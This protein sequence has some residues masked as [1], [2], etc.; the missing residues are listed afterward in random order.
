M[1]ATRRAPGRPAGRPVVARRKGRAHESPARPDERYGPRRLR[2]LYEISKVLSHFAETPEATVP[3]LLPILTRE[4]P[5]RSAILIEKTKDRPTAIVWRAPDV[6][7][8]ELK[9][10]AAR[11]SKSFAFLTRSP[12]PAVKVVEVKA[13]PPALP[14][15]R[16]APDP[17]LHGRYITC[18][19]A[20]QGRPIFGSLHL[21]G[22]EPFDEED[23]EFVN[24]ATGQLAVALE[25]NEVRL[26]EV[27]LRKQAESSQREAQREMDGRRRAEKEV[28]ELNADLERRVAERTAQFQDTI[29][30]L[31][32]FTYSIAHDLRAPL[33]HIHG[34]TQLLAGAAA[35]D[36]SREHAR[37]IMA[38]TEGMDVLIK[39]LLAYSRLTL[40]EI[41]IEPVSLA[42]VLAR[43]EARMDKELKQRKARLEIVGHLP[44]VMGHEA[45]LIQAVSNLLSNSL[46]FTA[47]G[48]A[49]RI[50]VT[51][52]ARGTH[53]RLW[54]E[55]N[56]IGIAPE[57]LERIFGVFQRLH[58]VE[59]YPGTGIGLA[60]VRRALERMKGRTGAESEPGQGSRF[61]LELE[62]A[63]S[64]A[65]GA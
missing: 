8:A 26:H 32:A 9:G 16:P 45:S 6:T 57:H 33:R 19:L 56:G 50:R 2:A 35:D 17:A 1:A 43:A 48:V 23:L 34:F 65:E 40:D 55:D 52:E 12:A 47:P 18:P 59:D 27:G 21:E 63:G 15:E 10:A 11:A 29:K 61:W 41:K 44:R 38:A 13:G 7:A 24:A 14:A 64:A 36:A 51:A 5:L 22:V 20:M 25:R 62:T 42:E 4:L 30:E 39:D 53:T 37:R 49:P 3:A 46:K 31:R 60:I 54:V 58:K 28:R